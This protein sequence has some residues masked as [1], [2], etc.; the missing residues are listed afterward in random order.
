MPM[1]KGIKDGT[2]YVKF[3]HKVNGSDEW[4]LLKNADKH[5][6]E[7]QVKGNT[8]TIVNHAPQQDFVVN[9]VNVQ[10]NMSV[11]SKQT[12]TYNITNTGNTYTQE[13][14]FFVNNEII[15]QIGLN[16]DPGATDDYV[17]SWT[18]AREGTYEIGL[19]TGDGTEIITSQKVTIGEAKSYEMDIT[20]K[21]D[22]CEGNQSMGYKVAGNT[23]KGVMEV[24]NL[25]AHDYVDDITCLLYYNG[26]DGY[27]YL[28]NSSIIP[29]EVKAGETVDVPFEFANLDYSKLY[30]LIV[31]YNTEGHLSEETIS[32]Y[33]KLID[34]STAIEGIEAS[35]E[36]Q[37]D[38]PVYNLQGVR[39]PDGA[40]LPKGIYIRGGKKFVVK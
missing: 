33:Y 31:Y 36:E 39:M 24:T 40:S 17:F 4:T 21:V 2:Y 19:A 10:G 16:L 27:M 22:D 11:G 12:F 3:V 25:G 26:N 15:S 7:L 6:L 34:N 28:T 18:P 38:Q 37:A 29:A 20:I 32:G 9:D 13:V 30:A 35:G 5:Y 23:I 14:T 8:A 1:G